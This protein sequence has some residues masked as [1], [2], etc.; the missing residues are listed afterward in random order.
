MSLQEPLQGPRCLPDTIAGTLPVCPIAISEYL[1]YSARARAPWIPMLLCR[2]C[3]SGLCQ[4]SAWPA[5]TLLVLPSLNTYATLLAVSAQAR[6]QLRR[7]VPLQ[8][9]LTP[10]P[11]NLHPPTL[12]RSKKDIARPYTY[13]HLRTRHLHPPRAGGAAAA[14]HSHSRPRGARSVTPISAHQARCRLRR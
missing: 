13:L 4:R 11:K 14:G 10:S 8:L 1:C 5:C 7:L 2:C 6:H 9:L 12:P 3:L